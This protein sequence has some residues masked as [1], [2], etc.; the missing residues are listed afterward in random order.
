[1]PFRDGLQ[2]HRKPDLAGLWNA[3]PR[4]S[5]LLHSRLAV[6]FLLGMPHVRET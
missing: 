2:N 1:L 5:T 4:D 3:G 6:V